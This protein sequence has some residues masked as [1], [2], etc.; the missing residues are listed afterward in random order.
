V[1]HGALLKQQF[2]QVYFIDNKCET[3]TMQF[4]SKTLRSELPNWNSYIPKSKLSC[5]W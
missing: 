5:N 1:V 2:Y 4:G 3:I